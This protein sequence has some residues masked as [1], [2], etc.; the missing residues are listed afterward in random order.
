MEEPAVTFQT[1]NLACDPPLFRAQNENVY[2]VDAVTEIAD[3]RN[4]PDPD[5]ILILRALPVVPSGRVV[6]NVPAV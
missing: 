4:D 5:A 3:E 2:A 1:R 6:D